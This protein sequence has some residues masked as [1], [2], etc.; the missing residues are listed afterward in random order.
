[1]VNLE[2]IRTSAERLI[3]AISDALRLEV[4]IFDNNS[5]LFFCTPTYLKKKGRIVHAPFIQDV[6]ANGSV[7]VTNPGEMPSCIGCRFK[8]HCPSTIEI[9]CCIH[10]G[11]NIAG[12]AAFTAFTKDG[13]R[14]ITENT[15]VYLNAITELANLI[16]DLLANR[17]GIASFGR[18]DVTL[19][20][21]LELCTQPLLLTDPQGVILQYN[22]LASNVLK[23]CNITSTSLWQIFPEAMVKKITEGNYLLDKQVTLG[24]M[25]TKIATRP[26][27]VDGQVTAIFVKMSGEL[28]KPIEES[29]F[30][31]SI[32]GTSPAIESLHRLIKK[33][34]DSPSPVLITGETGTG[35][36]LV[37][38]AIHEQSRRDKYPFVAIN[39]SSI[40]ETLFESELFGFE[41][42]SFTGAK[43]GGKMGKIE[44]AQ[45]GT[46]FLDEI[47][48]MPLSV[49]PKLLRI[50]QEY[51]LERVG[52]NK[53]IH[54]DIRII[55]ATNRDLSEMVAA[56]TFRG[57]LFYRLNVIHMKLPPLRS[58]KM[59][60]IPIAMNYLK[61]L[62][63][64]MNTPLKYFSSEVTEL[65]TNY[66][67]PGNVRELQNVIE[68]AAN[69]CET[70]T[71]SLSDLPE[72]ILKREAE[73]EPQKMAP[74]S[75]ENLKEQKLIELLEKYGYTLEGKK[76]IADE[77]NISLRTLYRRINRLQERVPSDAL[78]Q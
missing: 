61:K 71:L 52:S 58:R 66:S 17:A 4:A 62:H 59:D 2:E 40:P 13:Q 28:S 32:I 54:L 49:Q 78:P 10:A 57:D 43:K 33:M 47:G 16:G 46:L 55:A 45:G 23:L 74:R 8:E 68:Y 19:S 77:L 27:M 30:F 37:A 26:V 64:K 75:A 9:L 25:A 7:L 3:T 1:M 51:E 14:R 53:K 67:W 72:T 60:I 15:P 22:Q 41:E 73:A 35:K 6:L 50:L 65:F 38:R 70:D 39:C 21:A 18:H 69:L 63:L 20:E 56:R 48:E 36:E 76:R 29:S 24:N 5:S 42:G 12:V 34:S 31:G 44:M 11:T